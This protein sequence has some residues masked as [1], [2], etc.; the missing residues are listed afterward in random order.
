MRTKKKDRLDLVSA[1]AEDKAYLQQTPTKLRIVNQYA[2]RTI[3]LGQA[4]AALKQHHG[5]KNREAML[6]I[7]RGAKDF[8]EDRALPMHMRSQQGARNTSFAHMCDRAVVRLK[9]QE[10]RRAK[11]ARKARKN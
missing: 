3:T 10:K 11:A 7:T 2:E 9:N 5:M 1:H 8:S 4:L 6:F